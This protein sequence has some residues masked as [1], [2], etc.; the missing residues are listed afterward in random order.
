[1][2]GDS[3]TFEQALTAELMR[4]KRGEVDLV[5]ACCYDREL[6]R[7]VAFMAAQNDIACRIDGI[8]MSFIRASGTD[9]LG[10]LP[11]DYDLSNERKEE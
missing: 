9:Y 8:Q 10:I 6:Q 11:K 4:L 7:R 5:D 3:A 1:M 2:K